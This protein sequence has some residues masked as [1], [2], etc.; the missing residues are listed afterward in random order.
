MAGAVP[1]GKTGQD[2]P[3]PARGRRAADPPTVRHKCGKSAAKSAAQVRSKCGASAEQV[4]STVRIACGT[5]ADVRR[6]VFWQNTPQKTQKH[7]Q[8]H[9]NTKKDGEKTPNYCFAFRAVCGYPCGSA[10]E[11]R[12]HRCG[13]GAE[14]VRHRCGSRVERVRNGCGTPAERRRNGCGTP[15]AEQVRNAGGS[16]ARRPLAG[17]SSLGARLRL[18]LA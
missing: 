7:P 14:P 8:N 3:A 12:R 16:T 10:L 4:R 2:R 15:A 11:R 17:P 13:I 5:P 9:K 1:N 6:G 18:G